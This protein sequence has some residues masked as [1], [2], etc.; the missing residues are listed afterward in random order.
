MG[1]GLDWVGKGLRV[2]RAVCLAGLAALGVSCA[3]EVAPIATPSSTPISLTI[4]VP[5]SSSAGQALEIGVRDFT[6]RNPGARVR[7]EVVDGDIA[8]QLARRATEGRLPDMVWMSR[9]TLER[10]AP[11]GLL[12]DLQTLATLDKNV[13]P[14]APV[15]GCACEGPPPPF[16]LQNITADALAA[17]RAPGGFELLMIP[18]LTDAAA[19]P[20][21]QG[22]GIISG[23]PNLAAAWQFVRYLATEDGQRRIVDDGIGATVLRTLDGPALP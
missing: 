12:L 9:A 16:R 1:I 6:A 8:E 5:R 3:G 20:A 4:L 18:V 21:V 23:T 19:A 15:I 13:D 11:T 17:S 22:L 7:V 14:N 2:V 10:S